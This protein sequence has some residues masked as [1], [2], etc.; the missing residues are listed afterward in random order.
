LSSTCSPAVRRNN[1]PGWYVK[2]NY[3]RHVIPPALLISRVDRGNFT[4]SSSQNRT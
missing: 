2:R 1:N 4:P 3:Q